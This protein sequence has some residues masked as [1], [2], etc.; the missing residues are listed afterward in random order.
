MTCSESHRS[1][2]QQPTWQQST[3]SDRKISDEDRLKVLEECA[4]FVELLGDLTSD[5][6]QQTLV[7]WLKTRPEFEE[8]GISDKNVWAYFHDGRIA[9]FVPNWEGAEGRRRP[10]GNARKLRGRITLL[11]LPQ[12]E[13]KA[14]HKPITVTLFYGLGKAFKDDRQSLKDLFAKSNT[15]YK[16]DLKDASIENLKAVKDL[17]VFYIQTHGGGGLEKPKKIVSVHSDYGLQILS[18]RKMKKLY[19]VDLD[20]Y[21]LVYMYAVQDDSR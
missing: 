15:N 12:D 1:D 9:M 8:A 19:K 7:Q 20:A 18:P 10:P 11:R 13:H 3:A 21:R 4:T 16:V 2:T 14:Y 17:G 5:V 6:A